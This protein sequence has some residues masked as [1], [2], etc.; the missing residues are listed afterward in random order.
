MSTNKRETLRPML[1]GR[2]F[3]RYSSSYNTHIV[4]ISLLKGSTSY[5]VKCFSHGFNG[6]WSKLRLNF[7][8]F[9]TFGYER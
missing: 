4:T 3:L 7:A 1:K 8:N 5:R 9:V 2:E 6:S